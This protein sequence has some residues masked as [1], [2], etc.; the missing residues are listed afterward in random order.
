M[1]CEISL[2]RHW[3][4]VKT[5]YIELEPGRRVGVSVVLPL[6]KAC[7]FCLTHEPGGNPGNFSFSVRLCLEGPKS[8]GS[9]FFLVEQQM[10]DFGHP[11][12]ILNHH[13]CYVIASD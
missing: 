3:F 6:S 9:N 8:L 7:V 12:S 13:V 5:R 2:F 4:C 11:I 10:S 1:T